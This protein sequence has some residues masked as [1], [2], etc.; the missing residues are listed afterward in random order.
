MKCPASCR[1]AVTVTATLGLSFGTARGQPSVGEHTLDLSVPDSPAFTALGIAPTDVTHPSTPRELAAAFLN[2]ADSSGNFQ[3]AWA[4]DVS[5]YLL[6]SGDGLTLAG[7]RS[8]LSDRLLSRLQFSLGSAKGSSDDDPSARAALGARLALWDRGD[9]R[10]DQEL[11]ACLTGAADRARKSVGGPLPRATGL[12]EKAQERRK[13][14]Y[15]GRLE[16]AMRAEAGPC[17]KESARRLW[18]NSSWIVGSAL[19]GFSTTGETGD[20]DWDGGAVWTSLAYGFEGRKKLEDFAQIV[21]LYQVL[22]SHR[23]AIEGRAGEFLIQDVEMVGGRVRVGTA[24]FLGSFE[25][26]FVRRELVGGIKESSYRWSV[27]VEKRLVEGLWLHV[28]HGSDSSE[29]AGNGE[30]S[31]LA[32]LKWSG[33]P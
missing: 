24:D 32:S 22:D 18:N 27:A 23:T 13:S 33:S 6:W 21:L 12:P 16:N 26:V 7:Y 4:I 15:E 25:R 1:I 30:S 5:P 9:P 20:F 28:A 8:S 10:M 19:R 31:V 11:S 29:V 17:R 14:A 3:T 2:G